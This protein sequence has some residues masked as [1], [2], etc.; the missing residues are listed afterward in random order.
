MGWLFT[1]GSTRQELIRERTRNWTAGGP[2]GMTVVT[3][4][5]AHCYR[6]GAFSGVLWAVWERVFV[7]GGEVV[8]PT[9]RWIACDLL[10]HRRDDGWGYKDLEEQMHPFFYSCP[11][12]YLDLV[13]LETYGGCKEWREGVRR[14]HERQRET[15]R[16]RVR[17]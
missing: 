2:D 3:S 12:K 14:Y 10:R 6:G 17:A 1:R 13:P 11:A 8:K 16:R 15:R 5:L 9:E 7:R 4:C